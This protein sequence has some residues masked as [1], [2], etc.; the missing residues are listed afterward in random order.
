MGRG[1]GVGRGEKKREGGWEREC[2]IVVYSF[3]RA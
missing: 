1:G 2:I 3:C